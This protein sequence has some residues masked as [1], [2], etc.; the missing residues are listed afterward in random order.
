MKTKVCTRSTKNDIKRAPL[1]HIS[2]RSNT[3]RCLYS[4][5]RTGI[6]LLRHSLNSSSP[7]DPCPSLLE[8][9]SKYVVLVENEPLLKFFLQGETNQIALATPENARRQH[10]LQLKARLHRHPAVLLI[11]RG[12]G[13][14]TQS[15][16]TMYPKQNNPRWR[17][18]LGD[19]PTT[20]ALAP[21]GLKTAL[22]LEGKSLEK[23][24]NIATAMTRNCLMAIKSRPGCCQCGTTCDMVSEIL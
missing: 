3:P 4:K 11:W 22:T 7:F 21:A 24:K 16:S 23:T 9:V 20:P 2:H 6:F 1:F 5:R 8:K 15:R 14:V 19:K 17:V 12:L 18:H 13:L 10:R